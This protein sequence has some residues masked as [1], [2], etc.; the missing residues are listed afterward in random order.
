VSLT[1]TPAAVEAVAA[2]PPREAGRLRRFVRGEAAFGYLLMAPV[3]IYLGLLLL[4]PLLL[5]I[6]FSLTDASTG[7]PFGS[8]VGLKN[9]TDLWSNETFRLALRNSFIF[10]FG[11]EIGK[12]ILG[13]ALGFLLLRRF[14]GKRVLRALLVLPWTV[15][16]ALT[17]LG[18]LLLYDPTFSMLN[19]T[20]GS[21]GFPYHPNW[22]GEP[23][24]AMIAI[25]IAN[26]WRGFPFS[27]IILIA[28]MTSI[29]SDILE[30][31]ALDGAG[32]LRRFH[33]VIVPMIAPILFVGLLFDLVFSFTDLSVVYLLTKGGP[34]NTTH[35]LP[36]LAYQNGI[37]GGDLAQGAAI[38]LFMLPVFVVACVIMLRILR[39]REI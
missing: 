26:I 5:S 11:S 2:A 7:Q 35:I 29:P 8:W 34:E 24:P 13:T 9:F 23:V 1:R 30:S 14:R 19:R 27:A 20:T 25:M 39:R 17:T 33:Y 12:A 28:G 22:L 15:P 38:S 31:A 32:F 16:V 36:E 18:W 4:Y 3:L 21:I 10:T 6:W 37:Q